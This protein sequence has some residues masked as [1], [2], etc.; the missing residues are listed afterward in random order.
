[1]YL[2]GLTGNIA[3]GK[4]TVVAVLRELGAAVCDADAVV[5]LVQAPDGAAYAPIVAAFGPQ[6]LL[7]AT[8]GQPIDRAALG[9]IVFGDA[10]QLRL[11][12]S[13][14]HPAVREYMVAWLA[15]QRAAGESVVVIDAIKLIESGWPTICD[16]VW[17]VTAPPDQQLARLIT[18]RG[19]SEADAKARIA[20]QNSQETKIAVADVVIDNGGTI[21]QTR[22][23]VERHFQAAIN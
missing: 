21:A 14:V 9:R 8:L 2:I 5:H 3:C 15:Q 4:S 1:M 22:A 7:D 18:Q 12:E 10:D 16:A 20:A 23:Q 6:I 19:M 17:V 11:L 13:L